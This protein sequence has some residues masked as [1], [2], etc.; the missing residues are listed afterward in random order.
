MRSPAGTHPAS[1]A[2]RSRPSSGCTCSSCSTTRKRASTPWRMISTKSR[3]WPVRT[4]PGRLST[5]GLPRSRS[6]LTSNT[7]WTPSMRLDDYL[8]TVGVVKR[9]TVAKELASNGLVLI[10]G[11]RAKPAATVTVNDIIQIKGSRPMAVEVLAIPSGASVP[12]DQRQNYFKELPV[13]R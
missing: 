12:K 3:S 9:R 10:N 4:R 11:N 6:A 2:A 5:S 1:I 7:G 8:S 13:P